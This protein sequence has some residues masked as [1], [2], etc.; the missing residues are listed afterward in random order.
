MKKTRKG[1]LNDHPNINDG[2]KVSRI[3][4]ITKLLTFFR[5]KAATT[6]DAAIELSMLR[7]SITWYVRDLENMGLL[8][9]IYKR[10]DEHTG[11]LAKYYTA[12]PDLWTRNNQP[13]QLCLFTNE[14][15]GGSNEV[16]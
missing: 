9:S 2:A 8:Q 6:L 13:K 4:D 16:Y 1:S 11:Y 14:E 5:Y 12:N 3:K 7:N 10:P 15:M